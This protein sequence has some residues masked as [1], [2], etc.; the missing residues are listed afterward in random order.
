MKTNL[1]QLSLLGAFAFVG[2]VACKQEEKKEVAQVVEQI[3]GINLDYMDTNVKPSEDF[4]KHVNGKWLENNSIPDDRTRWGS[5]DEL[6]QKTDEDAL[7]ILKAAMADDKDLNSIEVLPGSDQEKAV[8]LFKTILD[9][10]SRDKQGIE[11][12]KPLLEKIASIN[13][14]E[15]LQGYL[16]EMEPQG[17]GNFFGFGVSADPKD[18][19]MNVGYLGT[20]RLGLPDRDY[21]VKDDADSKEVRKKYVAHITRMLQYLGDTKEEAKAQ[22]EQILAFETRLAEPKMDKVDRRDPLKRYNPTAITD[23]QKMVPVINWETYFKGIG[24]ESLDT[25]IVS[26]VNYMKAL[27]SVLAENNVSDWKTFLRWSTLNRSAGRLSTELEN[28]NWEF[29]SKEL[30]GQ[31]VQRPIEERALQTLNRS[32]GEALGKLYVDQKF[33]PE[34]KERAEKMIANVITAFENRISVLPWMSEETKK[35]AIEKLRATSVKVAYPDK[36]KD[37]SAMEIKSVEEG[38]SY[39]ENM[40]NVSAYNYQENIDKLGKPVDKSEWFMAPQVVN[41]YFNP[42]YNEIVFPAAILQPPFFNFTADD[43]VNYGGIGAVIGHEISHSFDDSGAKYDKDGNLN[44]W[45]TDA[46]LKEF[47]N[48]G[49]ALADQYSAIEVLP[50]TNINGAFT[51]GENIGDLGGVLAAYDAL[52]LSFDGNKPADIDGFTA[53]QR[54][55]MSWATVWRTLYRDEALKNQIK[56]D[57]HSP[58]MNRAV[59]PLLNIDAFYEAFDINEGDNMYIAPEERVRI[60]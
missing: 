7:A 52:Q 41:A 8:F 19:N 13:N 20:S 50:E 3:P 27:Q 21:Y 24:V 30:R 36:W 55:F 56:T 23:L 18:S 45:W 49:K 4:F 29:Y 2:L 15:D 47:Q 14:I 6:R 40:R 10:E 26:D 32:V 17:G 9:T 22:A 37:Y 46:D 35:K 25:V 11:P 60:W 39:L 5:F 16:I 58:G 38:G 44:N 28:A 51:L 57:P 33:P 1:K 48:L 59:Q 12:L 54:F 31:K 43:A 34:A 53:E 42:A